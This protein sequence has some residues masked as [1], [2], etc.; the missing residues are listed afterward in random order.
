MYLQNYT[1]IMFQSSFDFHIV[2]SPSCNPPLFPPYV[3]GGWKEVTFKLSG[4]TGGLLSIFLGPKHSVLLV[5]DSW[6]ME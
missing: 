4:M 1:L 5:L 6:G 2:V 3:K